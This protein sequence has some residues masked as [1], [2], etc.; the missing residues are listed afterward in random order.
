MV[1]PFVWTEWY[2]GHSGCAVTKRVQTSGCVAFMA[3]FACTIWCVGFD[4]VMCA[5]KFAS[6]Q[7]HLTV[8][9]NKNNT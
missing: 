5:P 3:S 2:C 6:Q 9:T 7:F 8:H 4:D 1:I